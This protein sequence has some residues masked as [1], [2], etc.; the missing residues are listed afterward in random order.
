MKENIRLAKDLVRV[1]RVLAAEKSYADANI[2][3]LRRHEFVLVET[4]P[5]PN[6]WIRTITFNGENQQARI[7]K[8]SDDEWRAYAEFNREIG[9][10]TDVSGKTAK[11]AYENL[12]KKT[13]AVVKLMNKKRVEQFKTLLP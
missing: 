11:E 7:W 5:V 10:I 9:F 6:R 12:K 2:S 3:F 13:D 4:P 1:A 8:V